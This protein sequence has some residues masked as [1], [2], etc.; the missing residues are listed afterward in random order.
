MESLRNQC[1]I[2]SCKKVISACIVF[3]TENIGIPVQVSSENGLVL[4]SNSIELQHVQISFTLKAKTDFYNTIVEET[5]DLQ[6][7][8]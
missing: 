3:L 2:L 8:T 6:I 4:H 1:K 5:H 7:Q